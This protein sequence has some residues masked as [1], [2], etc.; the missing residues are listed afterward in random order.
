MKY[1]IIVL[2]ELAIVEVE[3]SYAEVAARGRNPVDLLQERPY[4]LDM[5]KRNAA[6]DQAHE[7]NKVP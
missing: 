3:V 6:D 5:M 2:M 1:A 7:R 4:I